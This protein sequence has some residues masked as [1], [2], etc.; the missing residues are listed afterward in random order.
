MADTNGQSADPLMRRLEQSAREY[1]LFEAL[2]LLQCAFPDKPPI[3]ATRRPTDDPVRFGQTPSLGFAPG[4]I[5]NFHAG[6]DGAPPRLTQFGFGLFGPN[7]PLP[8]HLTEYAHDRRRNHA[9]PTLSAFL[10][11]FHHR[12]LSLFFRAWAAHQPA[13]HADRGEDSRL[14]FYVASLL[15]YGT[16]AQRNGDAV[17]D[18]AKL[19]FAGRL[20]GPVR[21]AEGLRAILA[22]DFAMPVAMEEFTGEWMEVP[23]RYRWRLGASRDTGLLGIDAMT[24]ERAFCCGHKFRLRLGPMSAAEYENLLPG[25]PGSRRLRDWIRNYAGDTLAWEAQLI[26]RHEE[27]PRLCLGRC[28]ELGWTAWTRSQPETRDRA[29][30]S[31]RSDT[32]AQAVGQR[33]TREKAAAPAR[34]AAMETT[35][36]RR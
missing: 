5:D 1:D 16:D 32:A 2:R 17:P 6:N 27:T 20:M 18:Q 9:D 4:S 19:F 22:E 15:G 11:L 29:D 30:V 23:D 8:L 13:L 35:P 31:V 36:T 10:D 33:N 26:L 12:L 7:G 14:S 24:G 3:G 21:N 34:R 25:R 28:G